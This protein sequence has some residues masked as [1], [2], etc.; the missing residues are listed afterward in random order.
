MS[1]L[2]DSLQG[3]LVNVVN[4]NMGYP[5]TWQ[6]SV[7]GPLQNAIVLYKDNTEEYKLSNMDYEP[8]KW[9]MEYFY[10]AFADLKS[11]VDINEDETVIITLPG[12][13]TEFYVRKV[14]RMFDG[15]TSIAYLEKKT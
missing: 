2:F 6:P 13:L 7:G 14:E 12:G 5:A 3:N 10:P 11:L 1:N 15:K 9:R 4:N 8:A